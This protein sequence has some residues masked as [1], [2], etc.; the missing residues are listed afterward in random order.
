MLFLFFFT[1]THHWKVKLCSTHDNLICLSNFLFFFWLFFCFLGED[2]TTRPSIRPSKAPPIYKKTLFPTKKKK[3]KEKKG[4]YFQFFLKQINISQN[5]I[6]WG[7]IT[8]GCDSSPHSSLPSPH[9]PARKNP[10]SFKTPARPPLPSLPPGPLSRPAFTRHLAIPVSLLLIF[11]FF[12]DKWISKK[13]KGV[14]S[15]SKYG[16]KF[17]ITPNKRYLQLKQAF[18]QVRLQPAPPPQPLPLPYHQLG[19]SGVRVCT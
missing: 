2:K 3:E 12:L 16:R 14:V 13:E 5:K 6:L 19:S 18:W 9:P 11:F 17:L 15:I 4:L 8:M 1:T 10:H 7:E